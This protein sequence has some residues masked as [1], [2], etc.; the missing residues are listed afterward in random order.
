MELLG[1]VGLIPVA[2]LE[3]LDNDAALDVLKDV[4]QRGVRIMLEERVLEAA[5]RDVSRQQFRADDR[6]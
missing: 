1:R 5:S 2:A 4:E 3:L 6:A